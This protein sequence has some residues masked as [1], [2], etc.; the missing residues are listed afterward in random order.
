M[1]GRAIGKW[2][3]VN[4]E[5]GDV[6]QKE[7]THRPNGFNGT[8]LKTGRVVPAQHHV[9]GFI[10]LKKCSSKCLMHF[11]SQRGRTWER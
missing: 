3:D 5:R 9:R 8:E 2:G 11:K 10:S 1:G 7:L 4:G 6:K